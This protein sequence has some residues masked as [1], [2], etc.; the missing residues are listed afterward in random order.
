[1]KK[2]KMLLFLPLLLLATTVVFGQA[3]KNIS[4]MKGG[5]KLTDADIGFLS[6]VSNATVEV[7]RG[8]AVHEATVNKMTYKAGQTLTA[9]DGKSLTKAID[10]F[11]KTYKTPSASRG[12]GMCY[13]WYYYCNAYGYCYYYK[14]WYYC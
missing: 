8:A 9:A 11:Q 1:M 12:A 7:S 10:A 4:A 14:Y 13:Y 2:I 5:T 3:E 6:M